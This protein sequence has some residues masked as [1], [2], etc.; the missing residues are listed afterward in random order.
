MCPPGA[1]YQRGGV[2][3]SHKGKWQRLPG[4]AADD[5]WRD[6]NPAKIA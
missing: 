1:L 2:P 4:A 5:F 3:L 6:R